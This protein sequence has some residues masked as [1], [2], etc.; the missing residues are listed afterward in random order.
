MIDA[1]I[2]SSCEGM[3]IQDLNFSNDEK[4]PIVDEG[5]GGSNDQFRVDIDC[6]V[7]SKIGMT[8]D[9]TKEAYDFYNSYAR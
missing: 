3:S 4:S 7:D 5:C 9:T 1:N 6:E 8:F 2:S